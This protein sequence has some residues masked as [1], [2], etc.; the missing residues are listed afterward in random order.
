MHQV[1]PSSG[2]V[3]RKHLL[4]VAD[5]LTQGLL[6]RQIDTSQTKWSVV[7]GQRLNFF[8]KIPI[9]KQIVRTSDK[10]K[11]LWLQ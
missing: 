2:T 3:T 6:N 5:N 11:L 4:Q 10:I 9:E 7:E 1:L 8:R